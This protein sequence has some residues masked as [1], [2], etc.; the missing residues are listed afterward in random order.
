MK[1]NNNCILITGGTSGIGL[2]LAKRFADDKNRVIVC[3]RNKD[4]LAAVKENYPDIDTVCCDVS[5][6]N[7]RIKLYETISKDHPDLNVLINNAGIQQRID[8]KSF[9]WETCKKEF[10]TDFGAPIHLS[11]L[12]IPLLNGKDNAAIINVTSGL[13]FR[14]PIWA[15]IYGASKSGIHAFTF[16]LRQQLLG[17]GID[18]VEII[19]PAVN[20]DLG[21]S[22]L[23]SSGVDLDK[24]ADSVYSDLGKGLPEIGFGYTVGTEKYTREEMEIGAVEM[25]K[26]MASQQ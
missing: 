2:A 17:T 4:K 13:A 12:F 9:D 10:A 25:A 3:G 5:S 26:M 22:G 16:I 18:V 8:F 7:E 15:P 14:P 1:L 23:H 21:G 11:G 24:F 6:E 20:T 19:P